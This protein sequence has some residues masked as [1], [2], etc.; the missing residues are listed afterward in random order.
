MKKKL[1]RYI[2]DNSL[3]NDDVITC[4]AQLKEVHLFT[5]TDIVA[6]GQERDSRKGRVHI[7]FCAIVDS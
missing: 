1:W 6:N 7:L 4:D 3:S 5:T 2:F